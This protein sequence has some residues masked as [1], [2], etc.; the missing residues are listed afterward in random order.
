[1]FLT[2][3]ASFLIGPQSAREIVQADQADGRVAENDSNPFRVFV[4][5][6]ASVGAL[7]VRDGFF[8]A[9]LPVIDITGVDLETRQAPE[10]VETS[11][12]LSGLFH[13]AECLIVFPEKNGWLDGSTQRPGSLF[14]ISERFVELESLVMMFHCRAIIP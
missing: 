5:H 12:D 8:E 3:G 4:R 7:V 6:Q 13:G 2:E 1:M 9:V 10:I 11:K 14:E